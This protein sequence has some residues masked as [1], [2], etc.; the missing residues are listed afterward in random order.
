MQAAKRLLPSMFA[1]VCV[2][3]MPALNNVL[4]TLAGKELDAYEWSIR[5]PAFWFVYGLGAI[6]LTVS[7]AAYRAGKRAPALFCA[8]LAILAMFGL[9]IS[10]AL[11]SIQPDG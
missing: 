6:I 3:L 5:A 11:A 1:L 10:I 4:K 8:T 2:I 9:P 7:F